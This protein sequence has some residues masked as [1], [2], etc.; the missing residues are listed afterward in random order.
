MKKL[1]F[2]IAVI[3][4]LTNTSSVFAVSPTPAKSKTAS[5]SANKEGL[6]EKLNEQI[7]NLKEK[8]A[9]RVSELN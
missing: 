3:F 6:D 7:N 5:S 2:I 8:I 9:S 1:L 4:F